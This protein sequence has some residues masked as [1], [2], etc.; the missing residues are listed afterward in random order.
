MKDQ[1]R[2]LLSSLLFGMPSLTTHAVQRAVDFHT[3]GWLNVWY[4]FHYHF[5]LSAQQFCDIICLH[6]HHSLSLMPALCDGCGKDFSLIDALDCRKDGLVIQQHIEVRYSL[7][8]P[9]A[10]EYKKVVCKPVRSL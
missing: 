10:L 4:L 1:F 3:S 2:L 9:A 5:D 7:S 8:D 6:Y